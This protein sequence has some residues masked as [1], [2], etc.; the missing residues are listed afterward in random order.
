[1][2]V[3]LCREFAVNFAISSK[4]AVIFALLDGVF[5][6]ALVT[7]SV[8]KQVGTFKTARQCRDARVAPK[9]DYRCPKK[10]KFSAAT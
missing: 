9:V 4:S 6:L 2:T 3:N 8:G 10:N 1:V 7:E 5:R